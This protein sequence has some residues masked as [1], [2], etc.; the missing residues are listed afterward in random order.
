MCD[1]QFVSFM[2]VASQQN[3]P[4]DSELAVSL[5]TNVMC[6]ILHIGDF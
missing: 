4:A 2:Y 5:P 1:L 3:F 6:S